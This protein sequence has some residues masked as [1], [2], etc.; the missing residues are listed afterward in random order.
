MKVFIYALLLLLS[1][2]CVAQKEANPDKVKVD[3]KRF[4]SKT[5]TLPAPDTIFTPGFPVSDVKVIDHRFDTTTLGF[6]QKGFP[7]TRR[8]LKLKNGTTT[9]IRNYII[10][11]LPELHSDSSV[12]SYQLIC[13]I[14]KLWLS[15]EIYTTE[16]DDE[17]RNSPKQNT[18]KESGIILRLE[19]V[20]KSNDQYIPLYRFDTTITGEHTIY[21]DGDQYLS[22]SL[23]ASLQKLSTLS[24]GEIIGTKKKFTG[25]EINN[26]HARRFN[27]PILTEK[28][29]KGV[30]LTFEA[31]R[32]N[33][34]SIKNYRI[35][36][37]KKSDYLYTID[38][39]GR[40][41]L[42]RDIYGYSDGENFFLY[43]AGNFFRL[44]RTGNTFNIYGA[45][46]LKKV[47]QYITTEKILL[48]GLNPETFSK[49]NT[50]VSYELKLHPYQLDMETG[51]L[52]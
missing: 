41:T 26:Y 45:K 17:Y 42:T 34:P 9:G 12:L 21:R 13:N 48:M 49:N 14:K 52:Y 4:W 16:Q 50:K 6:M 38:E 51:V 32:N 7:D 40:E 11:S 46:S 27:I 2:S 19:F 23:K 8:I 28:I 25:N 3:F 1:I 22:H 36:A 5:F 47:R 10:S 39:T 44:Y 31:F 15:D 43:S 18:P 33:S 24:S 30:Y 20:L 37:D 29:K 35:S